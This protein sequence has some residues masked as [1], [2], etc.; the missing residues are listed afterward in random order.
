MALT[1]ALLHTSPTL[2]PLFTTLCRQHLPQTEIFHMVDESLIQQTITAGTLQK[3]TVRRVIS[4]VESA[5]QIGADGMLVTCSSIGPAV[6]YASRLFPFPVVRV[7]EAMAEKAVRAGRRIG[8][9]ATLRTTLEPTTALLREKSAAAGLNTQI[10]ESLCE[11]AFE[12]VLAGDTETH[13][14]A[15]SE[16]L[17][18]LAKKVDLVVLAQAS[19]ARVVQQMPEVK[20]PVLS[21][22]EMAVLRTRELLEGGC[23]TPGCL[24]RNLEF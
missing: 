15:V 17:T 7:D 9:I 3:L 23:Q 2:T 19:M 12:A 4:M 24:A 13:D 8:V 1:L 5:A 14:R 21:S 11:G 20:V 18:E 6:S 22:P 10:E 16:A